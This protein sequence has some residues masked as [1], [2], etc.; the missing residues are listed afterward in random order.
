[1]F[2]GGVPGAR[3]VLG[4]V[5]LR[6]APM[7]PALGVCVCCGG[8]RLYLD[9]V[10]HCFIYKAGRKPFS[11]K[12]ED[13]ISL[14]PDDLILGIIQRPHPHLQCAPCHQRRKVATKELAIC[15]LH[16]IVYYKLDLLQ[17]NIPTPY[18]KV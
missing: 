9:V 12:D 6:L 4:V 7:Y 18:A 2:T 5:L 11:V 3:V 13:R 1:M 8:V 15:R 14:L 16:T 10:G 17:I